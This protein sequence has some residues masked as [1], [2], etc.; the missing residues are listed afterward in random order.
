MIQDLD[1]LSFSE[2]PQRVFK[3]LSQ[4]KRIRSNI[5]RS[6]AKG[7]RDKNSH[8]DSYIF[9]RLKIDFSTKYKAEEIWLDH[10]NGHIVLEAPMK[11][12]ESKVSLKARRIEY[13]GAILK[14]VEAMTS[15]GITIVY[16]L[17]DDQGRKDV[18]KITPIRRG[19][20]KTSG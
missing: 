12:N 4:Y 7:K 19:Q 2:A 20:R 15:I 17:L 13:Y 11:R 9:D 14:Q 8:G 10:V 1:R 18:G 5:L 16:L 3:S 6:L